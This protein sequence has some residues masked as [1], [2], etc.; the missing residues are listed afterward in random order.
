MIKETIQQEGLTLVKIYAL[1]IGAPKF[2]KQ[3]LM[4]IKGEVK[5]N[6]VIAGDCNTSLTL[7]NR[8]S[9]QKTNKETVALNDTLDKMDLINIFRAFYP[10]A[11]NYTYF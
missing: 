6:I 11:A 7:M 4:D 10:K 8:S 2:V 9:R 5:K 3:I 1:N